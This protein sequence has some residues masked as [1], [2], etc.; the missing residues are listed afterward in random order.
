MT[1]VGQEFE[2]NFLA[3]P[4]HEK[5]KG[6]LS[7]KAQWIGIPTSRQET[8]VQSLVQEDST[9]QGV[10]KPASHKY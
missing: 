7:L 4:I 9:R 8:W 10:T 6:G 3:N 2:L 1:S 5:S